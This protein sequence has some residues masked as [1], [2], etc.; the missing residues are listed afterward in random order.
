MW[1]NAETLNGRHVRL[2]PL[3]TAHTAALALAVAD[4]EL[5][6]LW[7]ANVP[8]PVDMPAYVARALAACAQGEVP[9]A[10]CEQSSG[11]V[12]GTT[13]YYAVDAPN[14]RA[15]IGYTWLAARTRGTPINAECKYLLLEKLFEQHAAIACELRT[16][17]ANLRSR[18]AIERLGA[19]QD[20]I[21]RHHQ[22]LRDGSLRDTVVYSILAEEWLA[23]KA[24][25]QTRLAR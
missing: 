25:L 15:L 22:I 21:L 23:V 4:G 19:H 16:H 8:T 1:L 9:F 13:R 11:T 24:G 10:I 3:T 2:E 5:W 6:R 14:R 17:V 12:L 20:G 18:V 7:Y